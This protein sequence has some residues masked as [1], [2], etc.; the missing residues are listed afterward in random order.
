LSSSFAYSLGA[1]RHVLRIHP[2]G[3]HG[4]GQPCLV[5]RFGRPEN[6]L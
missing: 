4:S 1:N 2:M 6:R 5:N 3:H